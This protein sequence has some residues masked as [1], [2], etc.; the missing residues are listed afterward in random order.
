MGRVSDDCSNF[1]YKHGRLDEFWLAHY[2]R[3][4]SRSLNTTKLA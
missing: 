4:C 1:D 2:S 3:T